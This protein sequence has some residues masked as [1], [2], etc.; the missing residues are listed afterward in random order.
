MADGSRSPSGGERRGRSRSRRPRG[1]QAGGE[2]VIE[3]VVEKVAPVGLA[4][5]PIL[6]KTNY[7]EW[8]LLMKIKLEARS[9]WAAVDKGDG[10]F[11]VDR[12]ALDA[13]CSAVP[14]DMIATLAV[15]PTTK[16]VW[17]CIK[18]M[19]IDDDRVRKATL[20]KVRREYELLSFRDGESVEDFA[21]RLNNV[22]TQ[23]ATLGDA[24]SDHKIVD[25]YLRIA[26]PRY[27]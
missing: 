7:N 4:N 25:K 10:E 20:Q 23:L 3:R 8:S 16:E 18:T 13:I 9:L 22:T 19:C 27:K 12:M 11:Q 2:R 21:M 24:E 14:P 1:E 17:D 26:R 5:Y 6:T 15:K